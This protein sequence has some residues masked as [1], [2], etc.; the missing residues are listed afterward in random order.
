MDQKNLEVK[1]F[2]EFTLTESDTIAY[3]VA[4][5]S[6]NRG[7]G[8]VVFSKW[9]FGPVTRTWVPLRGQTFCLPIAAYAEFLKAIPALS[10]SI[11]TF[12]GIL[13]YFFSKISILFLYTF[14]VS[15]Q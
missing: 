4:L 12:G 3:K 10:V 11:M 6:F 2:C 13:F 14:I 8:M 7:P 15:D 5:K 9:Y 1:T